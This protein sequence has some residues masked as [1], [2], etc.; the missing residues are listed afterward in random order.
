MS[1]TTAEN[2]SESTS[3]IFA[4]DHVTDHFRDH[5]HFQHGAFSERF[6]KVASH[7]AVKGVVATLE[8]AS[9]ASQAL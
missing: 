3:T 8:T 7:T 1:L 4:S 2:L 6:D 9:E 5:T